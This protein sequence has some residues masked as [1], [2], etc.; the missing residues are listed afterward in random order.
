MYHI[1][2]TRKGNR[3]PEAASARPEA[4]AH[5]A[6]HAGLRP[7]FFSVQ[8]F[9]AHDHIGDE[10]GSLTKWLAVEKLKTG[11]KTIRNEAGAC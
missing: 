4:P 1:R 11:F 7:A 2:V 8:W 5:N 3:Y 10:L 6:N 9:F